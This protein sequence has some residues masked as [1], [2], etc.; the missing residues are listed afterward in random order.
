MKTPYPT[1]PEP[2]SLFAHQHAAAI[3]DRC[4]GRD[5]MPVEGGGQVRRIRLRVGLEV[6]RRPGGNGEA[7]ELGATRPH[8]DQDQ[9]RSEAPI[10]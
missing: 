2:E 10:P 6:V 8:C 4:A 9:P 7:G 3:A 5:A 1:D